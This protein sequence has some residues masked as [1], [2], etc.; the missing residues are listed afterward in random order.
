MVN[1]DR[2]VHLDTIS[3]IYIGIATTWTIVVLGVMAFLW[4]HRRLPHLQ[5]RRLP[6]VFAAMGMLHGYGVLCYIAYV[7]G[8]SFPCAIEFWDMNILL[9]LGIAVFQI[10]NSQFLHIAEQQKRYTST[11]SL[12]QLV[13]GSK[14]LSALDGRS[15]SLLQRTASRLENKDKITRMVIY[16]SIGMLLQVCYKTLTSCN[17]ADYGRRSLCR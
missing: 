6:L 14:K 5:M 10:S 12:D 16:V 11:Q 15:G 13:R 2:G 4:H 8:I 3:R 17:G 7:I 1:T 9:P